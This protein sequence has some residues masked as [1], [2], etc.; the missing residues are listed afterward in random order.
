MQMYTHYYK[1]HIQVE[2]QSR[3]SSGGRTFSFWCFNPG[4]AFQDL[5]RCGV[6]NV[7]LCSGT[8][9]PMESFAHE[10]S[11]AFD[12]RLENPHVIQPQQVSV[13]V[14]GKGPT[15]K[16]LNSSFK[17]RDSDEYKSELGMTVVNVCR[18]VPDGVLVFFPSYAVLQTCIDFWQRRRDAHTPTL[19]ETMHQHKQPVVEP[20]D[21]AS[22]ATC[23]ADFQNKIRDPSTHGAVFFA[24]CRG[25]VSEGLD[26][27]DRNGRAVIVTGLPFPSH[28]DPKVRIKRR[29][30]D[31]VRRQGDQSALTGNDWYTQQAMRAVNQAIGRVIRH[32]FDYGAILLCDERFANKAHRDQLSL[33]LRPHVVECADFGR[34]ARALSVFF[35]RTDRP[36]N[37]K[38]EQAPVHDVLDD[39][40]EPIAL[41]PSVPLARRIVPRTVY[42]A[43]G[44][45]SHLPTLT[46]AL[47]NAPDASI[48]DMKA[49]SS[50]V[51][52]TF[53]DVM[54]TTPPVEAKKPSLFAALSAS[55][56]EQEER[57]AN[58]AASKVNAPKTGTLAE[59]LAARADSNHSTKRLGG[60]FSR[61]A[62]KSTPTAF[63]SQ[64]I[65]AAVASENSAATLSQP[66]ISTPAAPAA[67]VPTSASA[68][69][70][71]AA[72]AAPVLAASAP[73]PSTMSAADRAEHR[74]QIAK[75]Y[76]AKVQATLSPPQVVQFKTLLQGVRSASLQ[77]PDLVSQVKL[78]FAGHRD[79]LEGFVDFVPSKMKDE[80]LASIA[81]VASKQQRSVAS[82][83]NNEAAAKRSRSDTLSRVVTT[84]SPGGL[85]LGELVPPAPAVVA[86]S[87]TP[88]VAVA[89]AVTAPLSGTADVVMEEV[90][91]V[92][93][94]APPA[95]TASTSGGSTTSGPTCTICHEGMSVPF[96]APCGHLACYDCWT[97]WLKSRMECPVCRQ[98]LRQ[99]QLRKIFFS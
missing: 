9:S 52:A 79:L 19:W 32:R 56:K 57:V 24:V 90:A 91:F 66:L 6:R 80:F 35:K 55:R 25:K 23:M 69:P 71:T 36:V 83:T 14:I 51:A 27:A 81:R 22:L 99:K 94:A 34:A 39:N 1:V 59:Q 21:S 48:E 65:A 29:I 75:A 77:I 50:M 42:T 82:F 31:D 72:T 4:L 44:V 67:R 60:P 8:L 41:P 15:G 46:A 78:L 85:A 88:S 54:Q 97:T 95:V 26:F 45:M 30:L 28:T 53:L 10:L 11:L 62:I 20:R 3:T 86:S 16:A 5:M 43:G 12:I 47:A 63:A 98:H 40:G 37:P 84:A 38:T 89:V 2:K 70:S 64:T 49:V 74:Q 76:M 73:A 18:M 33:W 92:P 87:F 68:L 58:I 17:T 96:T 13:C 93:T 61:A 7:I